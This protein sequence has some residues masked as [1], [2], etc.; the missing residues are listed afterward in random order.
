MPTINNGPKGP[1]KPVFVKLTQEMSRAQ[2]LRNLT[3]A[4]ERSGFTIRPGSRP[5]VTAPEATDPTISNDGE[6][7]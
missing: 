4:L 5:T 1:M 6:A 3:Q 2:K 7:S